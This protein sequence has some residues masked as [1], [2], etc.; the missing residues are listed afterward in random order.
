MNGLIAYC[1]ASM[2]VGAVAAYFLQNR[3]VKE[4]NDA[5]RVVEGEKMKVEATLQSKSEQ[6]ER[7]QVSSA[8]ELKRQGDQFREQIHDLNDKLHDAGEKLD[9]ER[10][11]REALAKQL[12]AAEGCIKAEKGKLKDQEDRYREMLGQA[13]AK[14]KEIAQH[15]LEDREKKLK[16]DGMNP[17]STL[18]TQLKQEIDNLKKRISDSDIESGKTHTSLMDRITTLLDQTNKVTEQANNLASAIRGDAQ[19]T[20]EWGEIQLKRV[21]DLSGM[22]ESNDYSYQESFYDD[23]TGRRSKRTDFVVRLPSD[24]ALIIDSKNTIAAAERY[25]GA[26][27]AATRAAAVEEIIASVRK[28]VDEIDIAEYQVSVPNAL[29]TVLMY[30]PLEEVYMMAMKATVTVSGKQE[31]LRDYARRRNVV[32]VNSS[33]VV[34]VVRLI[35]MMWKIEKTEKNRQETIRAAE[36][37]LQRAND[38][39]VQFI[40]IGDAFKDVFAKYEAAKGRLIDAPHGQSITKAVKKL[41]DLG[42]QPKTRSGKTYEL[43]APIA[44]EVGNENP[45]PT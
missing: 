38:F 3:K 13:E 5:K 44:E 37:L 30:I 40:E 20:G 43:A 39:V 22:V 18:V 26:T 17:L 14:F 28:H 9:A 15:I 1:F 21:L 45:D 31:L 10:G 35:E 33:S 32:F 23:E 29:K 12:V 36:E 2:V 41:I 27:D 19:L 34:P 7:M 11:A 6:I 16:D 42:V 8:D 25:Q 4:A 24:R